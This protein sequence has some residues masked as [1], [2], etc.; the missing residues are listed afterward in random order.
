[1]LLP[2]NA[3]LVSGPSLYS[4]TCFPGWLCGFESS[5][6]P[7]FQSGQSLVGN[8]AE[9][10]PERSRALMEGLFAGVVCG[11]VRAMMHWDRQGFEAAKSLSG[12]D[13]GEMLCSGRKDGR[14][15][16]R[17]PS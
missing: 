14:W 7:A 12:R 10:I 8:E 6:V 2:L 1:M 9:P 16:W 13:S 11:S 3:G 15:P 17:Q 5:E 4:H